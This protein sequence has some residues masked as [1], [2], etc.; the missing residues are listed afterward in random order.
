MLLSLTCLYLT[1]TVLVKKS[2]QQNFV[3]SF[4]LF[5]FLGFFV[6]FLINESEI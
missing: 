5:V 3:F 4:Y 2:H 1:N 6:C